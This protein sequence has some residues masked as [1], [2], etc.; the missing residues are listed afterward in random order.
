VFTLFF[1]FVPPAVASAWARGSGMYTSGGLP[2]CGWVTMP[3]TVNVVLPIVIV[4]P[5]FS[6]CEVA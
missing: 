5:A 1:R 3:T 4:E 6:L 2:L